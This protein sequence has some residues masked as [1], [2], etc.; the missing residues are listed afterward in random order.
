MGD[1]WICSNCGAEN[2]MKFCTKCGTPKPV[3]EAPVEEVP[4]AWDCVCGNTGN[5][6]NFCKKCGR[7]RAEGTVV[8]A[9]AAVAVAEEVVP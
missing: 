1:K 9:A 3:V 4:Q 5:T 7:S 2:S 6:G 8:A